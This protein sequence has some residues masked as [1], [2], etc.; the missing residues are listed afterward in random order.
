MPT[1]SGKTVTSSLFA[2]PCK[3]SLHQLNFLM[4]RRGI[5]SE[6]SNIREAFSSNVNLFTKS[7]ARSSGLKLGF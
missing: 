7:S 2:K 6:T 1:G 3:A 4:P 5:A